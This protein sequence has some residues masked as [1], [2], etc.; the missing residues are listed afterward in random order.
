MLLSELLKG[1]EIKSSKGDLKKE[2]KHVHFDSRFI[3]EGSLFICIN[4]FK[5]TGYAYINDAINKGAIAI[6]VD[7]NIEID[8]VTVIQV[9]NTRKSMAQIANIF[10]REPTKQLSLIGVT[11]TN[12]KTS[13]THIIKNILE[14]YGK[15]TGLIGTISNW[16]GDMEV[17]SVR[18]TPEALDLQNIFSEMVEKKVDACVMEVSSHA[19]ELERV[20][21]CTY[22]IGVFTNL[23]PDHLDFHKNIDSYRN[24]KKKL[25][26]KTRLC[27][28]INTDDLHGNIIAEE[29]R[30]LEVPLITYGINKKADIYATNIKRNIKGVEFDLN[31]PLGKKIINVK[32]PGLFTVYNVMPSIVVCYILGFSLDEI[33]IALNNM[34][35]VPGRFE[36]IEEIK[37]ISVIIDYAHTPNALENILKTAEEFKRNRIIT[38]FGCGGDR[39]KTKRFSMGQISGEF[40]DY[41]IITSDNPRT[42]NPLNI[43]SMV[44]TGIKKVTDKYIIIEDRKIAIESAIKMAEKDDIIIIAGKG[45]EDTQTIGNNVI[46]FDDRKVALEIA[47]K[48]GLV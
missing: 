14:Y 15:R 17:K 47:R 21:G 42:E 16:I 18:T 3:K 32:I 1:I 34:Q 28:I 40:S 6:M 46:P 13:I 8:N 20:E 2:I 22:S 35:G 10:Y 19:L 36:I 44:E 5:T 23:T 48:E 33:G 45:H 12:G 11:G 26:Y 37:K 25:F 9:K 43:I 24:A 41:T 39:D 7:R 4:G 29:I 38:V 27:N 30:E 31:T